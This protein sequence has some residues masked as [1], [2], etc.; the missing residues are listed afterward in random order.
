MRNTSPEDRA[1]N[2]FRLQSA[3]AWAL[4]ALLAIVITAGFPL[5][6]TGLRSVDDHE[7]LTF[8]LMN[9][10][11]SPWTALLDGFYRSI[12]ELDGARWRPIYHVGR[13]LSTALIS[14]AAFPRYLWRLFMTAFVAWGIAT[15]VIKV[16][17]LK[18]DDSRIR[19]FAILVS[20]LLFLSIPDWT[21]VTTRLGPQELFALFGLTLAL[22]GVQV[23]PQLHHKLAMLTGVLLMS[24]YKE[25][26]AVI[27]SLLLVGIL[28]IN[29]TLRRES[30]IYLCLGV[31]IATS[32]ISYRAVLMNGG[33]DVY[34]NERSLKS[35]ANSFLSVA[36]SLRF[37]WSAIFI[38]ISLAFSRRGRRHLIAWLGLMMF[39]CLTTEWLIYGE[40][41]DTYGRYA[42]ASDLVVASLLAIALISICD[43]I[44]ARRLLGPYILPGLV[45]LSLVLAITVFD[46]MRNGASNAARESA[47]WSLVINE[48]TEVSEQAKLS[49][50]LIV[51][52]LH[53]NPGRYEKSLSLVTFLSYYAVAQPRLYLAVQR[54]PNNTEA[55]DLS[56]N[57]EARSIEGGAQSNIWRSPP[58]QLRPISEL[59]FSQRVL[60]ILYSSSGRQHRYAALCA[61]SVRVAQ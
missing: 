51:V 20:A 58:Q 59:E 50:L 15:R 1:G 41:M 26:F 10:A 12:G 22:L 19:F 52:D 3:D 54:A 24:G 16:A 30:L 14:D 2:P 27:A 11:G 42:I 9:P 17:T 25:N 5:L 4:I 6:S 38:V 60:C 8:R 29:R 32:V 55:S 56:R 53:E 33:T 21:D 47:G 45:L 13:S 31:S 44:S 40:S 37:E 23:G 57:L 39:C 18:L 28:R 34:G 49:D 48:I 43:R 36:D 7:Y 61:E 35:L 46:T